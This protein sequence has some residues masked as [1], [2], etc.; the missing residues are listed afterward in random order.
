MSAGTQGGRSLD[1]AKIEAAYVGFHKT[2]HDRLK[3]AA[4]L[5]DRLATIVQ[6]D[7]VLDSQLWL[8]NNPKMRRWVG[9]K[10]LHKLRGEK[11]DVKTEPQEASLEVP[12]HD[13]LNDRLGLY[14]GR[15][16]GMADAFSWRKDEMVFGMLVAGVAGTAYG[17][18]YDGQNLVDTDH[19]P[20][21]V[22]GSTNQSNKVTGALS[23]TTYA[24][25]FEKFIGFKDE[26]GIPANVASRR[27][28]LVVGEANRAAARAII[29]Q[30][31]GSSGSQNVDAGTSDLIVTGWLS[32]GVKFNVNGTEVTAT[33]TEWFLLPS[34]A[35]AVILQVKRGPEFIS[36]ETGEYAFRTGKY[37][38]GI[39]GELG[40][41]YG[42][43][44]EIV[45]GPGV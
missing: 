1:A 2:F 41:A 34:D 12:K 6:T 19:Q 5:A 35:T 40:T 28:T 17:T 42:L 20:L 7:N 31:T 22:G 9:D 21:S 30:Q 32:N 29:E 25:A 15:I 3:K 10:V 36:V 38:Y 45:G 24:Q 13:I 44:Q 26:N 11:H 27:M 37:L 33:G 8:A 4:P 39:E 43:W 23:G 16:N 18:T 14:T